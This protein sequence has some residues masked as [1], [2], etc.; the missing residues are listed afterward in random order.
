M[1]DGER[2]DLFENQPHLKAFNSV[3]TRN[4]FIHHGSYRNYAPYGS[5]KHIVNNAQDLHKLIMQLGRYNH[6]NNPNEKSVISFNDFIRGAQPVSGGETTED[7]LA[8]LGWGVPSPSFGKV[9]DYLQSSEQREGLR[10]LTEISKTIQST[11]PKA[12][13]EYLEKED[14]EDLYQRLGFNKNETAPIKQIVDNFLDDVLISLSSRGRSFKHKKPTLL[15][16][17]TSGLNFGGALPAF[18]QEENCKQKLMI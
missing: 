8:Y 9:K 5:D 1:T 7:M 16:A 14:F 4:P 6:L 12:I 2:K 11:N 13:L 15:D 3:L 17:V 10:F 18:E